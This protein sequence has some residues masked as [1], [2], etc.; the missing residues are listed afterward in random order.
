MNITSQKITETVKH[1]SQFN[2]ATNLA[3]LA[4]EQSKQQ[5]WELQIINRQNICP[6]NKLNVLQEDLTGLKPEQFKSL[7][8]D[9]FYNAELM[10][11]LMCTV[12]SIYYSSSSAV[13]YNE[14]IR[15]WL[16]NLRQIGSESVSGYAMI[17]SLGTAN[18][19]FIVKSP[20]PTVRDDLQH[21]LFIGMFGTNRLRKYVPNF[22]YIFGGFQCSPPLIDEQSKQVTAWC[23]NTESKVNYVLYENIAPAKSMHEYITRTTSAKDFLN[24][25]LQIV[26]ALRKGKEICDFSHYD[27]HVENV[28]IR[29]LDGQKSFYIPYETEKGKIEYM[30]TDAISTIIDYGSSHINYKGKSYGKYPWI[31]AGVYPDRSFILGDCYKFLL[32][33]SSSAQ[34][35]GNKKI[36]LE[37]SKILRF[38][39]QEENIAQILGRQR[40]VFYY[41][42]WLPESSSVSIDDYTKYIRSVCDCSFFSDVPTG[43]V[44]GCKNKDSKYGGS[45]TRPED[46]LRMIGMKPTVPQTMFEFYDL[47]SRPGKSVIGFDAATVAKRDLLVLE[48]YIAEALKIGKSLRPIRLYNA[49]IN[50]ILNP[51]TLFLFRKYITQTAAIYDL[52][53][54]IDI[55]YKAYELASHMYN[56]TEIKHKVD[57]FYALITGIRANFN[58]AARRIAEDADYLVSIRTANEVKIKAALRINPNLAWY[59]DGIKAFFF[60]LS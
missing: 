51:N 39:N 15:N 53:Q 57:E 55:L 37:C 45:C 2:T 48:K 52:L 1:L 18:D 38:F 6:V 41:L 14:R 54:R 58:E 17:S 27:L 36:L 49:N 4:G 60:M 44:I 28:L 32:H 31:S 19:S 23:N 10:S 11:A 26:Y 16:Q 30:L 25:Y 29:S 56:I 22:A 5:V 42:P 50:T 40:G 7:V 21:E 9:Q 12:D 33:C 34:L 35:V 46:V 43:K 20:R 24:K 3:I 59:W 8:R 47:A 13:T